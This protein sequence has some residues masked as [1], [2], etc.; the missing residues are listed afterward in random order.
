MKLSEGHPA[1]P[2]GGRMHGNR[3]WLRAWLHDPTPNRPPPSKPVPIPP[4]PGE[5]PTPV[6]DPL[7]P[8]HPDPVREPPTH[9]PPKS[10]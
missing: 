2:P 7:K 8:E 6:H 5:P 10:H 3:L 1:F 9:R 4:L